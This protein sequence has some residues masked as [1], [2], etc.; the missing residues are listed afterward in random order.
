[1]L[2]DIADKTEGYSGAE[3]EQL[4]NEAKISAGAQ[5]RLIVSEED[6]SYALHVLSPEQERRLGSNKWTQTK[7]TSFIQH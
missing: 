5:R 4:V 6:F 1:S 2:Q 7:E 3:L